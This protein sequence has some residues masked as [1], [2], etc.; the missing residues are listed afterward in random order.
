MRKKTPLNEKA[1]Q[2]VGNNKEFYLRQGR[3]MLLP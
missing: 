1:D 2:D 3:E